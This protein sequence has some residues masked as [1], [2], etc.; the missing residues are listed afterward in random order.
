MAYSFT[1]LDQIEAK[2]LEWVWFPY[3]ARGKAT[4]IEGD[5]GV[6]QS[7][8]AL[9]L[10]ARLSRG[11]VMPGEK[12]AQ[13]GPMRTLL[14]AVDHDATVIRDRLV[15]AG[16]DLSCVLF[17]NELRRLNDFQ[18]LC[19][20]EDLVQGQDIDLLVID[21][22]PAF[23]GRLK[24]RDENQVRAALRPL[25]EMARRQKIAVLILMPSLPGRGRPIGSCGV[26]SV[27]LEVVDHPRM[28]GSVLLFLRRSNIGPRRDPV[29]GRLF[30]PG[31]D[32]LVKWTDLLDAEI[33]KPLGPMTGPAANVITPEVVAAAM[34]W[35]AA[36]MAGRTML[37]REIYAAGELAGFRRSLLGL[38][39][40]ELHYPGEAEEVNGRREWVWVALPQESKKR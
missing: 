29:A 7:T 5:P 17:S 20:L 37:E 32:E 3:L 6:G 34:A 40:M 28:A 31:D 2:P 23:L 11:A 24:W 18:D 36:F 33:S 39:K 14:L 19:E 22:L 4:L 12:A 13:R 1:R 27:A 38:A 21:A 25:I 8:V 10:V 15:G 30:E 9:D 26:F 16:A 35:L